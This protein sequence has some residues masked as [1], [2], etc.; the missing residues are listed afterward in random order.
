[1]AAAYIKSN[2]LQCN[3]LGLWLDGTNDSSIHI[4]N[5]FIFFHNFLQNS[6]QKLFQ[7]I[8][9]FFCNL[10]KITIKNFDWT[11]S[12]RS[13]DKRIMLG[14]SDAWSMSHLSHR[15][16]NPAYY[17]EDCRISSWNTNLSLCGKN[18]FMAIIVEYW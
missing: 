16:S 7:F 11:N 5:I 6:L 8:F 15:P 14:T 3:T 18:N 2:N 13:Y 12:I 10:T 1:M 9:H 17:I 4:P